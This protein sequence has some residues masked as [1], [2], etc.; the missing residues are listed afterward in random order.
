MAL[1]VPKLQHCKAK[2]VF[3]YFFGG[4]GGGWGKGWGKL[5]N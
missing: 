3:L 5:F 4:G 1:D 2:G